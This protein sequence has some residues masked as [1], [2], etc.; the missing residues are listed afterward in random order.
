[1][2]ERLGGG[3]VT[4]SA[5][6]LDGSLIPDL[7]VFLLAPERVAKE[8]DRKWAGCKAGRVATAPGGTLADA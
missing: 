4:L 6:E 7:R 1:M 8:L 5:H 3:K 2:V